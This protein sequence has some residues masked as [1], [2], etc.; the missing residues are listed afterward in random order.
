MQLAPGT[1]V[2]CRSGE[3][4]RICSLTGPLLWVPIQPSS[5]GLRRPCL[6]F[7]SETRWPRAWGRAS[8]SSHP[9][10]QDICPSPLP[11]S[12]L[13]RNPA[14]SYVLS[15]HGWHLPFSCSPA[16]G[17]RR[18]EHGGR[19]CL[20]GHHKDTA[21]P[22][23]REAGLE[24]R[25]ERPGGHRQAALVYVGL[26][27]RVPWVGAGSEWVPA[28]ALEKGGLVSFLGRQLHATGTY[29]VTVP[30]TRSPWSR[31]RRGRA[32]IVP[33]GTLPYLFQLPVA[34]GIMAVLGL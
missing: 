12:A 29:S 16:P 2:K 33:E 9:Q 31:N 14:V 19:R 32:L 15:A 10:R 34:P 28:E 13:P 21:R 18:F 17:P 23:C 22:C 26:E 8:G 11:S 30:R 6:D 5:K 3:G 27:P 25:K 1:L 4:P 24:G 20:P 7:Q